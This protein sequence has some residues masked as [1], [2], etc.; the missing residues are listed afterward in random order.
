MQL[1]IKLRWEILAPSSV[2]INRAFPYNNWACTDAV[3]EVL[4]DDCRYNKVMA[5]PLDEDDDP[6]GLYPRL[7]Q[8][9]I[10]V[11]SIQATSIP[12]WIDDTRYAVKLDEGCMDMIPG[13]C[14]HTQ[15]VNVPGI[16]RRQ[17]ACALLSLRCQRRS[18][19]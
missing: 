2:P 4:W 1:D 7:C 5:V 18:P 3:R 11:R 17:E 12:N 16:L 15:C 9:P 13:I 6:I 19:C 8:K 14:H 10:G